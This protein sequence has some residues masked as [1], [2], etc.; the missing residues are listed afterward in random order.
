MVMTELGEFAMFLALGAG[1][2]ALFLGPIGRAVARRLE[3]R[4]RPS[5]DFIAD[6]EARV[7]E[8]EG[9]Q[10]RT[11]ELEERLAFAERLLAQGGE[12]PR[13]LPEAPLGRPS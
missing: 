7:G 10:Q 6:L 1:L 4:P 12:P 5:E 11:A 2:A 3:G 9:L 13:V 8:L